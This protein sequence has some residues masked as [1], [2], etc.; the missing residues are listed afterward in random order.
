[1]D[2]KNVDADLAQS[3][4]AL[5]RAALRARET[6]ERTGTPLIT[7]KNGH[8]HKNMIIREKSDTEYR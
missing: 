3:Q 8:V 5:K 6:A 1:M 2:K 7:Y 4:V